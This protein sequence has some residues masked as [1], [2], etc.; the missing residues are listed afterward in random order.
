M[1]NPPDCLKG[2]V[3]MH[4]RYAFCLILAVILCSCGPGLAATPP[5]PAFDH[6][7]FS[8]LLKKHV[9]PD[10]WVNYAALHADAAQ[11]DTYIAL[12]ADAPIDQLPAD[13]K[14][15]LLINA[16]NAFTLRLILDYRD[17]GKLKSIRDIP[18]EKSWDHVRWNLG[19]KLHS[20]N[21]I[22]HKQI[23]GEF[24]EPRIHWALVCAAFSCP[25]LRN[26]A[27]QPRTLDAQLAA[28][29]KYVHSHPRWFEHVNGVTV[30]LTPLYDWY[31]GDFEKAAGTVQKYVARHDGRLAR[32]LDR[33]VPFE[34]QWIEY[35]W[36][37][38]DI[39]NRPEAAK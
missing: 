17:D 19:G 38:N 5:A 37:L 1:I 30:R 12:L 32:L 14:L 16:Y 31:A 13:D 15:A 26:E 36:R 9:D 4:P 18:A 35:D 21:D 11:L 23:R 39:T 34:I 8:A 33:G 27:Y 24:A 7:A 20:L 3:V 6:S 28:Q 2:I 22:E 29:E 10:G 25:P